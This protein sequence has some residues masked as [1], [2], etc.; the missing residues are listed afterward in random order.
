MPDYS[1]F[2]TTPT[3]WQEH[4]FGDITPP[5]LA[6]Q[7]QPVYRGDVGD[8]RLDLSDVTDLGDLRAP[9]TTRIDGGIGDI[10]ILVPESADVRV[11]SHSGLGTIRLF[12]QEDRVGGLFEGTGSE[13]WTGDGRPEIQLTIDAAIG[14][15]V[16]DRA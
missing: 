2:P 13:A 10:T 14:D 11:S 9:I 5:A 4:A 8:L 3:A 12:D 7:V 15:V 1:E 6:A 16:V